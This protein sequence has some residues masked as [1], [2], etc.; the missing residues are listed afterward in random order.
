MALLPLTPAITTATIVLL[1]FI[2]CIYSIFHYSQTSIVHW[3]LINLRS[4]VMPAYQIGLH[5]TN[6]PR[7]RLVFE[8]ANST[9]TTSGDSLTFEPIM[10][11]VVI[12]GQY[13]NFDTTCPSLVANIIA[14]NLPA[15]IILVLDERKHFQLEH[16]GKACMQPFLDHLT[17]LTEPG[18]AK[19][20]LVEFCLVNKAME[21]AAKMSVVF[22]YTI[23][24]R[25]DNIVLVPLRVSTV[26]AANTDIFV[27][28]LEFRKALERMR[29]ER[30]LTRPSY[31]DLIWSWLLAAGSERLIEPMLL[32][33]IEPGC[34]EGRFTCLSPYEWNENM[35]QF[36]YS[37]V[38][39][40]NERSWHRYNKHVV[41]DI[42]KVTSNFELV[43]LLGRTWVQFGRSSVV[44]KIG[45]DV[46]K[47]WKT[48]TWNSTRDE[49]FFFLG[50]TRL[51]FWRDVQE[52]QLRLVHLIN[53]WNLVDIPN[54]AGDKLT[55]S[56]STDHTSILENVMDPKLFIW[57]LRTCD[58]AQNKYECKH[59][60]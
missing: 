40:R 33:P 14:P 7:R 34:H 38:P 39:D 22:H 50:K 37:N 53:K 15:H 29:F 4:S 5:E 26:F 16:I 55:F 47:Y 59:P 25:T 11:L 6:E 13:R 3:G 27:H 18:C 12:Y 54:D 60:S 24:A 1:L 51:P 36:I 8:D 56:Y 52:S 30:N 57:L 45:F 43:Y 31:Q 32:T 23:K 42:R 35:R 41:K 28:F 44:S 58:R 17:I 21:H 9:A 10:N 20:D 49:A 48:L 46:I 19:D 2:I